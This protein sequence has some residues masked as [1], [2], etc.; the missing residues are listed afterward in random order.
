MS[1]QG[2]AETNTMQVVA[3][4]DT[5]MPVANAIAHQLQLPVVHKTAPQRADGWQLQVDNTYRTLV[6]TDGA[7]KPVKTKASYAL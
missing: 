5:D 4:N 7:T 6:R 2:N 1:Q 3:I